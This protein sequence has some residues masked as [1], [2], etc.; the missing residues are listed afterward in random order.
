VT[1]VVGR[2][3][4]P[5]VS[6]ASD[7]LLTG[8][9]GQALPF[10]NG[11]IKS[12]M[13]PGNICVS[14]SNS[15]VT[16]GRAFKEFSS[17]YP[18]GTSFNE[19]VA[20]FERSSQSTGNDYLVAFAN[21]ARLIKIADG[22]RA[23]SLSKTQWIGDQTAYSKFRSYEA[24]H[25]PRAEQGR[26]INAVLFAD[27]LPDS[28]A[29]D[30][31]STM[32]NVVADRSVHTTGGFVSVVTNFDHGFRYSVYS[33]ML[34]DWPGGKPTDY[35]LLRSDDIAFTA[36]EENASFS[37][38]Q[39]SP[40]Y[41]GLNMVSFYFTRA[42]KLFFFFGEQNGMPDRCH[43]FG[44]VPATEIPATLNAFLQANFEWLLLITSPRNSIGNEPTPSIKTPGN[45][46]SFFCEANT[47][48]SSVVQG[49]L[50]Q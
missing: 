40:A 34:F 26:A 39:I 16:A 29:S 4:G 22:K 3:A 44:G 33:D 36:T 41:I 50:D 38:A 30:L 21:P 7:T 18:A 20:F 49:L 24:R 17:K 5:R 46:F 42:Q 47:F 25:Q 27:D 8:P 14:F 31:F 2:I 15:P 6:V 10:Q 48:P 13:L 32:R 37:I 28:P 11:V 12:C 43:V 19:V 35:Q 23:S 9:G 1:L 45:R